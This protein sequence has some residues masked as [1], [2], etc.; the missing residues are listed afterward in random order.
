MLPNVTVTDLEG[1][2]ARNGTPGYII[3]IRIPDP[4]SD[5]CMS[6]T[7]TPTPWALM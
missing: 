7:A 2:A 1:L 6:H 4:G 5:K 3:H